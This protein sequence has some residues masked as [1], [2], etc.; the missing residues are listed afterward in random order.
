MSKDNKEFKNIS[1]GRYVKKYF[2]V[3]GTITAVFAVF[4]ASFVFIYQSNVEPAYVESHQI[5]DWQR[6]GKA[7][8]EK[9]QED[10]SMFSAPPRTNF[11]LIGCDKIAGLTDTIIAGTFVS[12]TGEISLVSI[13]RDLYTTLERDKVR[14]LNDMGRNPPRYFKLNS[15]YAYA[16]RGETGMEYLKNEISEILGVKFDYYAM[17]DTEGFRSVV[18]TIGGIDFEVPEGGLFYEDPGQDLYINLKGG[19]QHLNGSQAEGLVRF[20]KGY[21]TQDLRRMEIQQE[22]LKVFLKTVLS[23]ENLSSNLN[24]LILDFIKYVDT[25]F[26]INDAAKYLSCISRVNAD[27]VRCETLPCEGKM[28]DGA[29]YFI[30]QEDEAK[31]IIDECFFGIKPDGEQES[32]IVSMAD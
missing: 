14:E 24:A 27:S 18:D 17:V 8:E 12:A 7:E 32:E 2:A 9:G 5:K 21:A 28:I 22:F 10:N 1:K 13:P 23:K 25:D 31:E 6:L 3:L 20:R 19:M 15:L 11:L 4:F 16:G 29:Y 30:L 26:G